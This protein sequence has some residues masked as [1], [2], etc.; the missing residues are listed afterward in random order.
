MQ[1]RNFFIH[2]RFILTVF[3]HKYL[4]IGD[5]HEA[6]YTFRMFFYKE[7]PFNRKDKV[8]SFIFSEI[9]VKNAAIN[10][11]T[12]EKIDSDLFLISPTSCLN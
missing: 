4:K 8:S 7:R 10:K 3:K 12:P 9:L 1:S 11:V 6:Q 2:L 5:T